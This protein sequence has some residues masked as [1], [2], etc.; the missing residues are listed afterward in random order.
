MDPI[1][2]AARERVVYCLRSGHFDSFDY[3]AHGGMVEALL[4][5]HRA[6]SALLVKLERLHTLEAAGD[7]ARLFSD[8]FNTV[9]RDFAEV[10]AISSSGGTNWKD[11]ADT[12]DFILRTIGPWHD[13]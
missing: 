5:S 6:T 8:A 13:K 12:I 10:T 7:T 3:A 1:E 9:A 2:R 4:A 11:E